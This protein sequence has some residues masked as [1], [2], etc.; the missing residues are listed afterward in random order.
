MKGLLTGGTR[1]PETLAPAAFR[2]ALA[3]EAPQELYAYW[4]GLRNGRPMPS[5]RD[6]DPLKIPRSLL[7]YL[8]V[9]EVHGPEAFRFRLSGTRLR[10]IFGRDV[11][12]RGLE[13]A[14]DGEDLENARRSYAQIVAAAAPWYS[15]VTYR[16]DDTA[17]LIYERL[18]LPVEESAD[19]SPSRL[20]GGLF[21]QDAPR[22][23]ENF[24]ERHRRH[25][26]RAIARF[27]AIQGA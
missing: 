26:L 3:G 25:G 24:S 16:V 7:P 27:E 10:E 14:L 5:R 12:G 20:L 1:R 23:F 21:I 19:G 18:S 13:D 6:I 8:Y 4:D 9:M 2:A 22:Q 15:R 11:T 17:D